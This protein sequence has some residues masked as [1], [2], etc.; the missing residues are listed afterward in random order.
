MRTLPL[1]AATA[2]VSGLMGTMPA[3]AA[4]TEE[5]VRGAVQNKEPAEGRPMDTRSVSVHA[6]EQAGEVSG[7]VNFRHVRQ[8]AADSNDVKGLSQFR[9]SVDCLQIDADIVRVAGT[10]ISGATRTGTSLTGKPYALEFRP[11]AGDFTLPAFGDARRVDGA[12][13]PTSGQRFVDITSGQ[14]HTND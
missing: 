1:L 8:Q 13:C 11:G 5:S 4:S 6:T 2:L 10:V 9:G 7:Q 14:L 3:L 12:E